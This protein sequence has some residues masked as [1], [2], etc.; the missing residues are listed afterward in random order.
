VSN[1]I[2]LR[3]FHQ[4]LAQEVSSL[5]DD[6]ARTY[7]K[8][9]VKPFRAWRD[10]AITVVPSF[11]I[12]QAGD[13]VVYYDDIEEEFGTATLDSATLQLRNEGTWGERLEWTLPHFPE[14][15]N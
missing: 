13:D 3:E 15:S 4:L 5:S 11:V 14:S 2:S 12:A 10:L 8:Y 6:I 9:A 7:R 1:H